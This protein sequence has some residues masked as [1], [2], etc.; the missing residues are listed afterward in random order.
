[1]EGE[2]KGLGGKLAQANKNIGLLEG[3]VKGLQNELADSRGQNQN[4]QRNI[5]SLNNNLVVC[6]D[7]KMQLAQELKNLQNEK[8]KIADNN[9]KLKKHLQGVGERIREQ[10]NNL[11]A[12][13]ADNLASRFKG[14]QIDAEV[15]PKTGTVT[16]LMDENLLFETN[17][18]RLSENAKKQLAKLIPIYADVL[19]KSPEIKERIASFNIEGHASPT[20][21]TGYVDPRTSEPEPYN[22]NLSLSTRRAIAITSFIFG[23]EIKEYP[24]KLDMRRLA[25]TIGHGY[26]KPIVKNQ[27]E[28]ASFGPQPLPPMASTADCKEYSCL[29]SQRVELSFTLK[30]DP[31]VLEKMI[32]FKESGL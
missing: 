5:A 3:D 12:S 19:L 31:E 20:F 4:L 9:K 22:Y 25:Q 30:D 10:Q 18:A 24:H 1:M 15:D 23:R 8:T 2:L 11:R 32:Q 27:R 29:L 13:I 17:S 16:L 28:L 6:S 26:N 7:E 14:S 21:S